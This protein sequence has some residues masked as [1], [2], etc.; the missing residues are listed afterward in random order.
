M[1]LESDLTV[2]T[3]PSCLLIINSRFPKNE[4]IIEHCPNKKKIEKWKIMAML[5][6]CMEKLIKGRLKPCINTTISILD[7]EKSRYHNRILINH[8]Y[9]DNVIFSTI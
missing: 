5:G 1:I 8:P 2:Y 6:K 3:E 4:G 7:G 9:L